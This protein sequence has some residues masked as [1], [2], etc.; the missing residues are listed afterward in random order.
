MRPFGL[1]L[2]SQ[3]INRGHMQSL[4]DVQNYLMENQ[5]RWS[6]ELGNV[7]L[8]I[9]IQQLLI[10][11]MS[12]IVYK[13]CQNRKKKIQ[14]TIGFEQCDSLLIEIHELLVVKISL[15]IQR[16]F[17]KSNRMQLPGEQEASDSWGRSAY[18]DANKV[19]QKP[20]EMASQLGKFNLFLI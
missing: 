14:M 2:M 6:Q 10:V 7:G 13:D 8:L 17:K 3:K 1:F 15:S 20:G 12:L 5:E 9:E 4:K 16:D 19:W 18:K 11:D